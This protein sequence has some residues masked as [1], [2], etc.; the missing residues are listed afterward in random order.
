MLNFIV[1]SYLVFSYQKVEE[2]SVNYPPP[3][4]LK[5]PPTVLQVQAARG[6]VHS[7]QDWIQLG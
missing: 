5:Y 6:A 3:G 1:Y 7:K 4:T 2:N